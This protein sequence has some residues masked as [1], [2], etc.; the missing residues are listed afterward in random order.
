MGFGQQAGQQGQEKPGFLGAVRIEQLFRLINGDDEGRSLQI[1]FACDSVEQPLFQIG[2]Q[3]LQ[4]LRPVVELPFDFPQ[5][6][7]PA[8]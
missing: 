8:H 2:Q 3:R 1:R 4:G 6:D 5:R 7:C